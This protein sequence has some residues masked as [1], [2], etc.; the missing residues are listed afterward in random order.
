M[1]LLPFPAP[2]ITP[3]PCSNISFVDVHPSDYFYEAVRNLYCIRGA[4]SGYSDNTFRP[5]NTVVRGQVAKIVVG[6][7]GWPLVCQP[8]C[9]CLDV[10]PGNPF[11]WYIHTAIARYVMSGYGDGTFKP[12]LF[13]TR[14]QAAKVSVLAA[15][16]SY[17][18]PS[19]GHFSDVPPGHAFFCYIETAYSHG[20]IS[21]YADGTFRPGNAVTRGQ[22]SKILYQALQ[23]R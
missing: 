17:D 12:Y 16:W 5:G 11:Y 2:S 6:A 4:I 1:A 14:G 10:L 9:M 21:G 13:Y 7:M 15:G 3:T 23:N 8:S 20:I 18:C 22:F 19:S